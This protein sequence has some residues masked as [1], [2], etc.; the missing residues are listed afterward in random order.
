MGEYQI[1][2]PPGADPEEDDEQSLFDEDNVR[3]IHT[4]YYLDDF[5]EVFKKG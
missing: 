5:T 2:E 3:A 4:L 1:C